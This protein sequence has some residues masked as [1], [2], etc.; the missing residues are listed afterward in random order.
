MDK[1][2]YLLVFDDK[3]GS[4]E[5]VRRFIDSRPEIVNWLSYF[6]N[7]FLIVSAKTANE[8]TEIFLKLTKKSGRFLIVDTH[9]DRNG[10]LP[11]EAWELM[12]HP[13]GVFDE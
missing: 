6:S 10:W 7:S 12:R 5:K 4:H 3:V 2:T 9:T 8:L 1:W 13:K 11:K